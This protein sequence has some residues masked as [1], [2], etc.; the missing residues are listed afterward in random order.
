MNKFTFRFLGP[1]ICAEIITLRVSGGSPLACA[2]ILVI[3]FWAWFCGFDE[4]VETTK[5]KISKGE[6]L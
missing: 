6:K 2:A 4:G 1:L 5:Q 3:V